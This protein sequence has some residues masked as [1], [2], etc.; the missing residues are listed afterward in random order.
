LLKR[1]SRTLASLRP[2]PRRG[3]PR[4]GRGPLLADRKPNRRRTFVVSAT[5][6]IHTND[7]TCI[8]TLVAQH[9]MRRNSRRA[10]LWILHTRDHAFLRRRHGQRNLRRGGARLWCFDDLQSFTVIGRTPP[11]AA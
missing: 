9:S 7:K 4:G 11:L 3:D 8:G 10:D 2:D 6:Y 1:V 5:V